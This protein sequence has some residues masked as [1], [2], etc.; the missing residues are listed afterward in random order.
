VTLRPLLRNRTLWIWIGVWVATRALILADVG[1]WDDVHRLHLQ[2]VGNYQAWS[3][4]LTR[5]GA[6]PSGEAWQYPPGAAL[7]MLLP[8]V[9]FGSCADSFVA[10]QRAGLLA[11]G[12]LALVFVGSAIAFGDPFTFLK[13]QGDRGLQEKAVATAPWQVWQIISGHAPLVLTSR[14]LSTQYMIW[15]LGLAAVVLSAGTPRMARPPAEPSPG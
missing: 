12:A 6:F 14:V 10:L 3:N 8:R 15:L 7:V 1:F 4:Q 11:L 9:G 13:G 2:D 5:D